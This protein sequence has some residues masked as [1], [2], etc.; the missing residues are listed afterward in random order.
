MSSID[1]PADQCGDVLEVS[2]SV[3][4]LACQSSK[5]IT[6]YR[7]RTMGQIHK[8]HFTLNNFYGEEVKL[9]SLLEGKQTFVFYTIRNASSSRIGMF[10]VLIN[11]K[12]TD[13]E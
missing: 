10:E 8:R 12:L 9:I 11:E 1:L 4:V 7:R 2:E 13:A 3:V 6:I 5:T